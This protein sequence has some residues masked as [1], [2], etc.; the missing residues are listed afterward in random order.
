M[1]LTSTTPPSSQPSTTTMV[2]KSGATTNVSSAPLDTPSTKKESAVKSTPTARNS[3]SS[4]E[5]ASNAMKAIKL[6]TVPNAKKSISHSPPISDAHFGKRVSA[7][8]ALRDITS[9]LQRFAN[10][11]AISAQLGTRQEPALPAIMDTL[12]Q[13]ETALLTRTPMFLITTLFA[14]SGLEEFAPNALIELTSMPTESA[15]A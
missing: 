14:T 15:K 4:K 2:V 7:Q 9:I 13:E 12:S 11:L 8:N 3:T 5:S 10:P 6:S 1:Q